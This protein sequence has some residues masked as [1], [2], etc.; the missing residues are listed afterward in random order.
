[1]ESMGPNSNNLTNA[2]EGTD[3]LLD[4]YRFKPL[5]QVDQNYREDHFV[6]S[7]NFRERKSM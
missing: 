2:K 4:D 6:E 3:M 7:N 5:H 1:M